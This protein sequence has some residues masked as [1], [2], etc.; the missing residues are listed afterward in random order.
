MSKSASGEILGI[1]QDALANFVGGLGMGDL[2]P[3]GMTNAA[4]TAQATFTPTEDGRFAG[5]LNEGQIANLFAQ[6]LMDYDDDYFFDATG[7]FGDPGLSYTK[8]VSEDVVDAVASQN[9]QRIAD[10]QAIGRTEANFQPNTIEEFYGSGQT[11]TQPDAAYFQDFPLPGTSLA[12]T[13]DDGATVPI[14][15]FQPQDGGADTS[16]LM[17]GLTGVGNLLGIGIGSKL[18]ESLLSGNTG[19][20]PMSDSAGGNTTGD[21]TAPGQTPGEPGMGGATG[22]GAANA[23]QF[24]TKDEIDALMGQPFDTSG[25]LTSDDLT[26]ALQG[27]DPMAGFD[28]T[29]FVT[30]DDFSTALQGFDPMAGLDT[31]GF[32]TT[33]DL[34]TALSD[35]NPG[36]DTSQFVTAADLNNA[37]TGFNPGIDT[38][39][40]V[41]QA[42]LDAMA[43]DPSGL[44]SQ[45]D[46]LSA[47]PAA[48]AFDPTGLQEEIDALRQQIAGLST[49]GGM[50]A[51]TNQ[52]PIFDTL[53]IRGR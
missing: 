28:P 15:D 18:I 42:D 47:V 27:F 29:G 31:S 8:G 4:D 39:S 45:I 19:G 11:I 1:D 7:V 33:S 13:V 12:A 44:Q 3:A 20:A 49:G 23:G 38:S 21:P 10:Q 26:A 32:V 51:G 30:Q 43:F 22:G 46:A 16:A 41:T 53:N 5:T 2:N 17:Q 50:A 24:Y 14:F 40:F 34:N 25:F 52:I 6:D 9:Q 36:I 48:T 35:F 37:L